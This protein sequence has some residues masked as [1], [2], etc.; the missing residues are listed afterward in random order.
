MTVDDRK[1][2]YARQREV[3]AELVEALIDQAPLAL[4]APFAAA[5]RLAPDDTGRLRA[6][7][8][9]AASLTDARALNRHRE[10]T[11]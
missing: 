4:D 11:G 6:V 8:D 1:P 3:L 10:L 2:I 9:Q 5:W 7:I